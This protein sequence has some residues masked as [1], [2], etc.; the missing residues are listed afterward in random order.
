VI[1]PQATLQT[2][3]ERLATITRNANE[4]SEAEFTKRIRNR[5][6]EGRFAGLTRERAEAA[7]GELSSL[8]DDYLLLA[9]VIED[10]KEAAK[11]GFL[12]SRES[13]EAKV[14]ALLEGPSIERPSVRVPL[15]QRELLGDALQHD[16]LTPQALLEAMQAAFGEARDALAAIDAAQR[17]TADDLADL[18]HDYDRMAQRAEQLQAVSDRPSFVE[19]QDLPAD[20]LGAHEGIAALRRALQ[21]WSSRLDELDLA[22][23]T[24]QAGVLQAREGLAELQRLVTSFAAQ[25]DAVRKLLGDE[26][27]VALQ[28]ASTSPLATLTSWCDAIDNSLQAHDWRAVNVG[29]SR[30]RPAL[31]AAIA[32]E[33]RQLA[34]AL[35][36]NAEVDEIQGRF[37]ALKA[38]ER[39]LHGRGALPETCGEQ[40]ARLDAALTRRP[41]DL[42]DAHDALAHYQDALHLATRH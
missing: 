16:R 6:R 4:L 19:L 14:R 29:L 35:A 40:R 3:Q 20:P 28:A 31:D 15:H 18:R 12:A 38:K 9:R 10:A 24:A 25:V 39:A 23:T 5:L 27:A 8:M 33:H 22:R 2:W 34:A 21:A 36:R 42:A 32:G 37:V 11:P 30:F 41:L 13:R 1:D 7:L 17:R 26:A